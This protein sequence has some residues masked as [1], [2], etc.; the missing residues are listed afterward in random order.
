MPELTNTSVPNVATG[1]NVWAV[2]A[3]SQ[4]AP[5]APQTPN[6]FLADSEPVTLTEKLKAK[7]LLDWRDTIMSIVIFSSFIGFMVL[8]IL[9]PIPPSPSNAEDESGESSYMQEYGYENV[10]LDLEEGAAKVTVA[11]TGLTKEVKVLLYK[12]AVILYE[13][14]AQ[15]EEKMDKVDAGTY[16]NLRP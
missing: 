5:S 9:F 15:L 7:V 13:T 3:Q 14:R 6:F 1:G 10:A 4:S 16:L 8:A 11:E 12:D 2:P